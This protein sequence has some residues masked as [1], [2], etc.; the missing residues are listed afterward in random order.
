MKNNNII[1]YRNQLFKISESFITN[2]AESLQ[3]FTPIYMGRKTF[4]QAPDNVRVVS[5][6]NASKVKNINY[7]LFRNTDYF[8]EKVVKF[9]PK[10]IHAH[11][12]V[13]GVYAMNL[14]KQLKIPLITTFHGFDATTS[15]NALLFSKKPAW[16]NYLLY[17]KKLAQN[18]DL[19]ICVSNFIREKVL[20]LGFPEDRT[21]TH[22]IGI[23][24]NIGRTVVEKENNKTILHVARLTEKKGTKYLIDAFAIIHKKIKEIKLIIIGTGDLENELKEQVK[25]L[26]LDK[27]VVFLGAQIHSKV[28]EWMQKVDVFCL[29]S[30]TADS[31]DAEGLGMVFLEAALYEVPTVATM[32]G[33]IPEVVIDGETGYLVPEKNSEKLAEKLLLL[34]N[35]EKL[36]KEMGSQARKMVENKFDIKK[37]TE[38]L[39]EIYKGLL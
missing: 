18:G 20:A 14:A 37:Q 6:D 26:N 35:N 36:R 7:V 13:E 24:I 23:D 22:Y 5:M 21:I 4:G 16:I 19:F 11:F 33:G 3:G 2:Q 17:R 10:L 15:N 1:I 9:N 28:L 32:H 30:V 8:K 39:E 27:D 38:R 25:K 34:L 29:P 12:G 31:G